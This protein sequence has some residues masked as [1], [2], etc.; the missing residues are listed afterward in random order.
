[1]ERT[2]TDPALCGNYCQVIPLVEFLER[3]EG[4]EGK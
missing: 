2:E 1:M 4:R 3:G